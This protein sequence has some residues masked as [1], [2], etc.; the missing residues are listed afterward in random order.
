MHLT[1][2]TKLSMTSREIADLVGSRH[3]SVKRTI[4]RLAKPK[5]DDAPAAIGLPPLVEYL[6]SLGRP[7]SEYVFSGEKGKRDSIV[8][9]AQLCP[10]FTASLVDRWQELEAKVAQIAPVTAP[11]TS[12]IDIPTAD[13]LSAAMAVLARARNAEQAIKGEIARLAGQLEALRVVASAGPAERA[14][15]EPLELV[16]YSGE[17]DLFGELIPEGIKL[18]SAPD[19]SGLAGI[20]YDHMM[21]QLERRGVFDSSKRLPLP[22]GRGRKVLSKAGRKIAVQFKSGI[23]KWKPREALGFLGRSLPADRLH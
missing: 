16:G 9:V 2:S 1:D 14:V 3:D 10:D 7:A 5:S 23:I 12:L 21:A 20:R 6:D 22:S 18:V 19:L 8:V 15:A 4:E 13:E 17:L 11:V